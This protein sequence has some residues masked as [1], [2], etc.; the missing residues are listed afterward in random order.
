MSSAPEDARRMVDHWTAE[1]ATSFKAY[2]N[3]SRAELSAAIEDAHAHHLKVTGHLCSVTWPEAIFVGIDDFE[4]GPVFTDTRRF[5]RDK[6]RGGHEFTSVAH[7]LA[8]R[9]LE[10]A[11]ATRIEGI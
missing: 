1:G 6:I 2:M 8:L 11:D 3:I 5:G 9:A 4:H 10:N 7:G